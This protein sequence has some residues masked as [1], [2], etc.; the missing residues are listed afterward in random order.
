M[1]KI[2]NINTM[3]SLNLWPKPEYND[4]GILYCQCTLIKDSDNG[5]TQY[6]CWLPGAYAILEN[7]VTINKNRWLIV[8]LGGWTSSRDIRLQMESYH[9]YKNNIKYRR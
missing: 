1:S 4:D 8:K 7:E 6:V 5:Y 3:D 9:N 2:M